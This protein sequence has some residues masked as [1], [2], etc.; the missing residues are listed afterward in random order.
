MTPTAAA[1][2]EAARLMGGRTQYSFLYATR[3]AAARE[4][5]SM[6]EVARELGKRRKAKHKAAPID[7]WWNE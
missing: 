7:A 1:A 6:S 5:V 3:Q 2:S 4:G